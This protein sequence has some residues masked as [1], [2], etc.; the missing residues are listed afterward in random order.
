MPD[1]ILWVLTKKKQTDGTS[2]PRRNLDRTRHCVS[3]VLIF[4]AYCGWLNLRGEPIVVVFVEGQI[5]KFQYPWKSYFLCG[6]WGKILWPLF[7]TPTNVYFLFN[8]RELVNMIIESSTVTIPEYSLCLAHIKIS[9]RAIKILSVGRPIYPVRLSQIGRRRAFTLKI[10]TADRSW[11]HFCLASVDNRPFIGRQS[12]DS[13]ATF[14]ES[15]DHRPM[16]GRPVLY[17]SLS[18]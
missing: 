16:I 5:R 10:C 8:R 14:W 4:K 7:L 2:V 3:V 17:S 11:E 13:R 12:D 15:G 18:P 6:V 1:G 9:D